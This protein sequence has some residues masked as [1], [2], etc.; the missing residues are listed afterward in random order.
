MILSLN[1][2]FFLFLSFSFSLLLILTSAHDHDPHNHQDHHNHDHTYTALPTFLEPIIYPLRLHLASLSPQKAALTASLLVSSSSLISL[3]LLPLPFLTPY[4][5]PFAAGA[6]L[7]D[8][9]HHLLPKALSQPSATP[10]LLLSTALF[11]LLDITLR[12]LSPTTH[13]AA[14]IN[15]LADALHN[16]CDGLSL[17]SAFLTSPAAGLATTL[18]II[19]HELPQELAD[20]AV[21]LRSGFSRPKALLANSFCALTALLGTAAA[22]RAADLFEHSDR[23]VVPV[24]AGAMLY[25]TF[26]TVLPDVVADV[27]RKGKPGLATRVLGMLVAAAAGAAVVMAVESTHVH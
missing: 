25:L 19:L 3:L 7:T 11:T 20:Y 15:L 14:Y 8:T 16:F 17:A 4:L 18:A 10:A 1:L 12:S 24:A 22:L 23:V 13:P 27:V 9:F 5:L 21:L 26:V 2:S 6:L